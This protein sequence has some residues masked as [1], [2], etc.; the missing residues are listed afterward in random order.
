MSCKVPSLEIGTRLSLLG[1][2]ETISRLPQ[3]EVISL[4][5]LLLLLLPETLL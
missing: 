3:G 5:V 2:Q 4:R 1:G